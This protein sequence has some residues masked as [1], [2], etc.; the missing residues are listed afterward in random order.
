MKTRSGR[1]RRT[2]GSIADWCLRHRHESVA[3]Q[4]KALSQKINGHFAYFGVNGNIRCLKQLVREVE[5]AWLY[6]LRSRSQR[7]KLTWARFTEG[8]LKRFPLPKPRIRVKIWV[9]SP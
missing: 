8:V 7:T 3:E 5:R 9:A 2:I 6:G 1:L 4:H